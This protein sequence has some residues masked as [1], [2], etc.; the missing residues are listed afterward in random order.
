MMVFIS[1]QV[2][3][4][5]MYDQE[6]KGKASTEAAI[7]ETMHARENAENLSQVRKWL[8]MKNN[9]TFKRIK[10]KNIHEHMINYSLWRLQFFKKTR[11]HLLKAPCQTQ[12]HSLGGTLCL[13]YLG[14]LDYH[15]V[16]NSFC[17]LLYPVG[18]LTHMA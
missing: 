17:N 9:F 12:M 6:M 18:T 16:F 1:C 3:Y 11:M 4:R 13:L 14:A 10:Y 5:Q 15:L 7:A 8:F 2:K